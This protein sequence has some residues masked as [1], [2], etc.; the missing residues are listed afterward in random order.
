MDTRTSLVSHILLS[1]N[2]SWLQDISMAYGNYPDLRGVKRVLVVKMRHHGD[3]LLTSPLF[4]ALKRA[5]PDA[6]IDA[7]LYKD[8]LP[9]L[10]G[11]PAIDRF[12]LYD[13]GWKKLG[14][15]RRLR[16]EWRLLRQVR[17]AS[18]DL[19]INLTEG[20]RGAIVAAASGA[21]VRAGFDPGKGGFAGKK[22]MYT[23]L[24]KPCPHPRHTVE[25]QLDVA[26]RLGVF[27]PPEERELTFHVPEEAQ[28]RVRAWVGESAYLLVHPASRWRFKCWPASQVAQLL[29]RLSGG[30]WKLVLSSGPDEPEI[31]MVEE[32]VQLA[33]GIP[34]LNLAGK[35]TLKE[36]GAL[37]AL[38][39]ALVCVDSVPL[40]LA[41]ALKT[42]VVAL[43]GPSSDQNWGPW[44]HPRS[45][46]VAQKLPCRPC[47]LDGC[48]GSK[49]SDCLQTL[50]VEAVLSAL[51]SLLGSFKEACAAR[52]L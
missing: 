39:E 14:L 5:L 33:P 2:S 17:R 18:Y 9:M 24:V 8:T 46:V 25:R 32:I 13:R 47:Y 27:P 42:P 11:H 10:E 16:E 37:I 20:D 52:S 3:V 4:S 6:R 36:L 23:H 43:F 12:L 48:G 19:V 51:E 34:L 44:R 49:M 45:R 29:K 41:S 30:P 50:P 15:L 28:E 40:H 21:R 31:G 1:G 7:L 26:R 22:R 38:S 35:T